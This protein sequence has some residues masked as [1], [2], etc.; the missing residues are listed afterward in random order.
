ML[1]GILNKINIKK[2]TGTPLLT[3]STLPHFNACPSQGI[4]FLSTIAL[5]SL[6][7][8]NYNEPED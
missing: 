2:K 6:I 7:K 5:S 1:Y 4:R 3:S 8:K